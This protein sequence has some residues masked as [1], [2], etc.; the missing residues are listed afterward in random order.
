[1]L[2][3]FL[4]FSVRTPDI[5]ESL[6]FYKLLGFHEL[7]VG[8]VWSHKYAV[9]SD[10]ELCIGLHDLPHDEGPALT[11]VH[12]ELA[13]EARSMADHGFEFKYLRVDEDVFNELGLVC[14]DGHLITMIEA[15]TFTQPNA[16]CGDSLCG[17]WFELTLP[18]RD[19]MRAGRFWAPLAPKLLRVR[20]EPTT[21][22]RFNAAGMSLGLSESI[23][24]EG[25]SL[26]FR[27][28]D[29]E[30]VWIALAKHGFEHKEFPGFEG[31]FMSIRSPDGTTLF[32][33]DEDFLGEL[34]EV[35]E[36]ERTTV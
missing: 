9:V 12:Q 8:E 15:R 35:E 6:S 24:L 16:D 25:P 36:T 32:L 1:M 3:Q 28:D 27:C 30:A 20:E 13:R 31:A 21:H 26:C 23:A 11:F 33:F 17:G 18:V 29:R 22:M 2:G 10:G 7:E 34:Y 14:R 4:E 5:I 19:T